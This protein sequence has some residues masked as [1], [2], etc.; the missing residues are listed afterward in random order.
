MADRGRRMISEEGGG[1]DQWRTPLQDH[2]ERRRQEREKRYQDAIKYYHQVTNTTESTPDFRKAVTLDELLSNVEAQS[3]KFEE[4]RAKPEHLPTPGRKRHKFLPW[5]S[6]KADAPP[7]ATNAKDD[8]PKSLDVPTDASRASSPNGRGRTAKRAVMDTVKRTFGPIDLIGRMTVDTF[9]S[10]Y[11]GVAY[12]F[13]AVSFLIQAARGVSAL[14]DSIEEFFDLLKPFMDRLAVYAQR[15]L[16][17]ELEDL[18]TD[19]LIAVIR[20]NGIATSVISRNRAM[21]FFRVAL[22]QNE[23]ISQ[24]L[25]K[26]KDLFDNESRMVTALLYRDVQE[27]ARPEPVQERAPDP[28]QDL[29]ARLAEL[30]ASLSPVSA[31]GAPENVLRGNKMRRTADTGTWVLSE[32]SFK[33]WMQHELPV[34][35]VSGGPGSG[36][37]F[38]SCFIVQ[39]LLDMAVRTGETNQNSSVAY[40]F[41]KEDVSDLRTFDAALRTM[42]YQICEKNA[43][44]AE[45]IASHCS[46]ATDFD[47]ETL[48]FKLFN[49]YFQGP[50]QFDDYAP[51]NA[52][53]AY[54]LIDGLDETDAKQR[55]TFLRTLGLWLKDRSR[56]IQAVRLQVLLLGRPELTTEIDAML[57]SEMLTIAVTAE[58]NSADIERYI[59]ESIDDGRLSATGIPVKH[60]KDFIKNFSGRADGMF[61]WADLMI[62]EMSMKDDFRDVQRAL[63]K[64]PH[65]LGARILHTLGRFGSTLD[66]EK[67]SDL[68]EMLSWV[69]CAQRRLTLA[70]M[71]EILNKKHREDSSETEDIELDYDEEMLQFESRL[72]KRYAS[73]FTLIREDGLSTDDLKAEMEARSKVLE[74]VNEKKVDHTTDDGYAAPA[75]TPRMMSSPTTEI[76]IAHTS[77]RDFFHREKKTSEVGVD[78][79]TSHESITLQ[80]LEIL[81]DLKAPK[82]ALFH[83]ASNLWQKHLSHCRLKTMG[84]GKKR[85][86][87]PLIV[88]I[89]R[90]YDTCMRWVGELQS[91]WN[92]WTLNKENQDRVQ[93]WLRDPDVSKDLSEE[94]RSWALDLGRQPENNLISVPYQVAITEWLRKFDWLP[95]PCYEN[96]AAYMKMIDCLRDGTE[97]PIEAAELDPADPAH[98][99]K[100][101]RWASIEQD[102]RWHSKLGIT[103]RQ[104]KLIEA[105]IEEHETALGMSDLLPS[106]A[107]LACCYE[108]TGDLNKAVEWME[109]ALIVLKNGSNEVQ[110][111]RKTVEAYLNSLGEWQARLN[112]QPQARATWEQLRQHAKTNSLAATNLLNLLYAEGDHDGLISMLEEMQR[113]SMPGQKHSALTQLCLQ[114]YS[115]HGSDEQ[116]PFC[117]GIEDAAFRKG[118]IDIVRDMY[119]SAADKAENQGDIARMLLL[120][121]DLALI[122]WRYYQDDDEAISIWKTIKNAR[123]GKSGNQLHA[124]K[125]IASFRLQEAYV[126]R[127]VIA[128]ESSRSSLES[129]VREF[130]ELVK[131]HQPDSQES[132]HRNMD[133]EHPVDCTQLRRSL[134]NTMLGREAEAAKH[135]KTNVRIGLGLLADPEKIPLAISCLTA[136]FI[137]LDDHTNALAALS[138]SPGIRTKPPESVEQAISKPAKD[139]HA[140]VEI[141][142][143]TGSS[144]ESAASSN[145]NGADAQLTEKSPSEGAPTTEGPGIAYALCCDSCDT[146]TFRPYGF[147]HCCYCSDIDFCSDCKLKL[148]KGELQMFPPRKC[149]Q[150]HKFLRIP[151]WEDD[152]GE[153]MVRVGNE[154][155]KLQKWIDT[156]K[157]R[158]DLTDSSL[159]MLTGN[160][161][162]ES[163][164]RLIS[165]II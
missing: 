94:E 110:I 69:V 31:K 106:M 146:Q 12:A 93:E 74:S 71:K 104:L 39:H 2:V 81:C 70:E 132:I 128:K 112:K 19:V 77:I 23:Q 52:N 16:S 65:E 131:D 1:A 120:K 78:I 143:L 5:R 118:K 156:I 84:A 45:Y 66:A 53:T 139:S 88:K 158:W 63:Q 138:I 28:V 14:Y 83:Y 11:P 35:W 96:A 155:W 119:V 18:I 154:Q 160:P 40:F 111:P 91:L 105:A 25:A 24:E 101:A 162:S 126:H 90:H 137:S 97:F 161:T 140:E 75:P 129:V 152:I 17:S 133:P 135:A 121:T 41:C 43:P 99:R 34:L 107:S 141:I 26:L 61:L 72:R 48:W 4:V 38:L 8:C 151:R 51:T 56:K 125:R 159:P 157:V 98:V 47:T 165:P 86:L 150:R 13:G 123:H 145:D 59:K 95:I 44:Y 103:F 100:V 114:W 124:T 68:N 80:L 7:P 142:D 60:R 10:C 33:A 116:L 37:T 108:N 153:D 134:L 149:D 163:D 82:G 54:L 27:L 76:A 89:F 58:K 109:K 115:R 122:K 147:Y 127:A 102:A 73:L 36:K 22:G 50:P 55:K 6:K 57:R 136:V 64:A 144:S 87:G 67:I 9:G 20:T 15:A 148:D 62:D 79:Q 29:K 32:P 117:P 3:E 85:K 92:I 21:Q 42:S 164:R 49:D 30:K 46:D 130:D 113:N